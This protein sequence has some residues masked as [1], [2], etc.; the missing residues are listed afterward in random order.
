MIKGFIRIRGS[1]FV[2][3]TIITEI[4]YSKQ[5]DII[6]I[7]NMAKKSVLWTTGKFT[8]LSVASQ[9]DIFDF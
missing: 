5:L 2:N 1:P 7:I 3:I 6:N 4:L 8:T 9:I